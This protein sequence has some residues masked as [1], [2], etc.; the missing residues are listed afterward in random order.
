[1]V[2]RDEVGIPLRAESLLHAAQ[3]REIVQAEGDL[4]DRAAEAAAQDRSF[5][6]RAFCSSGREY[7]LVVLAGIGRQEHELRVADRDAAAIRHRHAEDP[8]VEVL[9][10]R[11]VETAHPE[12]AERELSAFDAGN[13]LD[14][15]GWSPSE[16][17]YSD[18]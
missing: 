11:E 13:A 8:G 2:Q 1:M 10:P 6:D 18:V 15:H 16:M 14:P 3:G 12:V 5:H 9:H 7:Q 17:D 4:E